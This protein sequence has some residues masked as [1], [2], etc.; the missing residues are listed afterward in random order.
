MEIRKM[1]QEEI[2]LIARHYEEIMKKQ[3][4][5]I[6]EEPITEDRYKIILKKNF[7]DS[8]MFVLEDNGIKSF[9]WFIKKDGEINLEELFS[10]EKGRG[11]GNKLVR[12]LLDYSRKE[13][14]KKINMDVHFKNKKA[15]RFFKR[16]GFTERT[17]ELSLEI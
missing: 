11:Y 1:R 9:I 13:K 5:K 2:S 17:I 12:F 10:I 3:F 6:G 14:I 7:K 15:L 4:K 16:F 8:C